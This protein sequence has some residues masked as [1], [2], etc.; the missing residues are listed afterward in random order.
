MEEKSISLLSFSDD[1][2]IEQNITEEDKVLIE[3]KLWTLL[4]RWTERYTMGDST[5]VPVEIAEELLKSICFSLGLEL[6][7]SKN[8]TKILI[9]EDLEELLKASWIK[10]EAMIATGKKLLEEVRKT[11]SNIENISYNDTLNEIQ[12]FFNKYDYRFFAHKIECSIDYQLSNAVSER[13][14]GIEYINEYL[15]RLLIENK[16]CEVFSRQKIIN[17]LNSYCPDYKGLLIN[18]F[19]PVLT[20]A[21]GLEALNEYIFKLEISK[22]E[23]EMLLKLF[24]NLSKEKRLDKLI[25]VADRLCRTLGII[26]KESIEYIKKTAISIYPRVEV[27]LVMGSIENIFLSFKYEEEP[28]EFIFI[29]NELMDNERLCTLIDEINECRFIS[30]KIAIVR[31]EVKSIGDLVEIL[32]VCFFG[33]ETIE[34]FKAFSKDELYLIKYYLDTRGEYFSESKWEIELINYL[35]DIL[36]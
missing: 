32:N 29:D 3:V 14:E 30:D 13:L 31:K 10:I 21:I 1:I 35:K 8:P 12:S 24:K 26:D 15:K 18:I 11:S 22:I 19:E 5:S 36:E 25:E 28:N 23:Q 6:K 33:K 34:L 16:F 2:Q 9:E 20:N 27:S 17:I 4:G 7:G